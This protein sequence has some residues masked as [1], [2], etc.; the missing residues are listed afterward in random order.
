MFKTVMMDDVEYVVLS[1]EPY[2]V[3]ELSVFNDMFDNPNAIEDVVNHPNC[4]DGMK[5]LLLS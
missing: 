5:N 2:A 4:T 1:Q 3:M